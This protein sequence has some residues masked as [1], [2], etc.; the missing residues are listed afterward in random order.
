M[1]NGGH[2]IFFDVINKKYVFNVLKGQ[3]I[4]LALTQGNNNIYEEKYSQNYEGYYNGGYYQQ[5]QETGDPAWTLVPST[6]TGWEKKLSVL[7]GSDQSEAQSDLLTRCI[8]KTFEVKTK[9][10]KFGTDYKLGDILTI[11]IKKHGWEK[12]ASKRVVGVNIN[13][14]FNNY[15]EQPIL[16]ETEA[17]E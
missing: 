7:N 10:I 8:D 12:V 9:N 13:Y 5:K 14:E 4:T 17:G 15:F 11:K 6:K 2:E 3:Q 16:G 1:D